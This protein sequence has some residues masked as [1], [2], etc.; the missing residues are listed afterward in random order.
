MG[1]LEAC[2][3]SKLFKEALEEFSIPDNFTLSID[4]WPYG[5]PDLDTDNIRYV[6]AL[7]FARDTSNNNEDSNHYA[8]PIPLV[9]VFDIARQ[10]LVRV[11]RCATGGIGDPLY[12]LPRSPRP[13]ELFKESKPAEYI[14][15]LLGRPLRSDVKA[16]NI[17]Q[18]DGPSFTVSHGNLVE[19]QKWR[20]RLGFT[21]REGAVLHDLTYDHRPVLYRLSVSEMTVPYADP[22]PPFH[23]KY[24]CPPWRAVCGGSSL[25]TWLRPC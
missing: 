9:P 12:P 23:H 16:L 25:L 6:Q 22:R 17:T 21:R 1:I 14:P 5:G 13:R 24:E 8:Y 11:D 2:K 10:E 18:P 7:V 3:T 4:P 20:F 19:W 15:E